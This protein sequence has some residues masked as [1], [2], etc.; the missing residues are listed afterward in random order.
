MD[1]LILIYTVGIVLFLVAVLADRNTLYELNY[2][3]ILIV[4]IVAFVW[5]LALLLWVLDN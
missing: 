1:Y 3:Q 2:R 5:P 4:V